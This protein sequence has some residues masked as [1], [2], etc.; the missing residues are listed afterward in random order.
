M[1]IG[2]NE[3]GGGRLVRWQ[4]AEMN[5]LANQRLETIKKPV[6]KKYYHK[7]GTNPATGQLSGRA[8]CLALV[9][10]WFHTQHHTK[11]TK[12]ERKTERT[13]SLQSTNSK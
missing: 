13:V 5:R 8:I 7:K 2:V 3:D 9:R 12:K 1:G 10:P 11:H 4:N 6:Q